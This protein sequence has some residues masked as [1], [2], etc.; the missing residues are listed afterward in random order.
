MSNNAQPTSSSAAA[1]NHGAATPSLALLEARQLRDDLKVLLHKEQAAMAEFLVALSD[2]D[3][4]RG[5]EALGHASLFAFLIAELGLST[6]STY[7]RKSAAELLQDFPELERHL[8]E[9]RLCLTTMAELAKVL[10]EENRESVLPRFL[11]IS[12][13]EA[14]EIVAELQPR[15][16]P[17]M[18]TVVR[19]LVPALLHAIPAP[20]VFTLPVAP[21]S[22]GAA[23]P[24]GCAAACTDG[25]S[26]RAPEMKMTHP[27]RGVARRDEIDPLTGDLSRLSATVSRKF[28]QK[29]KTARSGLSHAIPGATLEQVLEAGL[30]LLL[31]KQARARGQLRRP[32]T[33]LASA[34]AGVAQPSAAVTSGVEGAPRAEAASPVEAHGVALSR[35]RATRMQPPLEPA[36]ALALRPT[37]LPPPSRPASTA[38]AVAIQVPNTTEPPPTRRTGPREAIPAAVRRAVWARDGERCTWPL[39]GGGCCGSTHRLELDH[40]VPWAEWGPSTVENLRVVC[41]RH[42]A[43]AARRAFGERCVDRYAPQWPERT[44]H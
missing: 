21:A 40:V 1:S 12:S 39:D 22:P 34:T 16:S 13:R 26:L 36:T 41:A 7:W 43:L 8:R 4:R 25:A 23:T 30:D 27:A 38:P 5:W 15:E 42:N 19:P 17:P 31:E 44:H 18:R 37:E 10:T 28:L 32:R 24:S 35:K 6:S 20:L 29:L 11:G 14:K 9:G 2:F 33:T 3:R